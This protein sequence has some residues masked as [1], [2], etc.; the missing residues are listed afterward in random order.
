[1]RPPPLSTRTSATGA[2]LPLLDRDGAVR[3]VVV[4]K[5]RFRLGRASRPQ[6]VPGAEIRP[7]D[8]PW[9][10]DS[11]V[12]SI[13]FPG[14][15]CVRKPGTDVVV[16]ADAM[17]PG[18]QAVRDLDVRV[19]VGTMEKRLKVFGLR[20]WYGGLGGTGLSEP[21]P[22]VRQPLRWEFAWGGMDVGDPKR[23]VQ[24]PR[25]PVGRGLAARAESLL[26]QPAPHVEDPGHLI[27][28]PGS[29]PPPAGVAALGPHFAQRLRHAGTMNQQWQDTRAPLVPADFDERF[30]QVAVPELVSPSHLRGGEPVECVGLHPLGP[31]VFELPRLSFAAEARTDGRWAEARPVLDTVMLFP[32]VWE[33]ELTWRTSFPA[34]DRIDRVDS[35][36]LF[37]KEAVA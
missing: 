29:R 23:A 36:R 24:E 25:N 17:A 27:Q 6:R 34:P 33:L 3:L 5:Q 12:S 2:V 21:Q 32:N 22:F 35:V 31:M 11:P 16:C 19:R 14:D 13:R 28:T 4:A 7:V 18:G 9:E 15:A 20:V 37:E 30:H 26:G 8:V 10:P 1:M